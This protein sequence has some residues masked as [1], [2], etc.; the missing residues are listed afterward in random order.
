MGDDSAPA[1][2]STA[3][4]ETSLVQAGKD[5]RMIVFATHRTPAYR[6]LRLSS[7]QRECS[8]R[9]AALWAR[10]MCRRGF[11]LAHSRTP[12]SSSRTKRASSSATLA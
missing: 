5:R 6:V 9:L 7:E 2:V 4:K 11:F 12:A 1:D 10:P 3:R 8:P